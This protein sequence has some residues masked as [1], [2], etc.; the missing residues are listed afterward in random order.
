MCACR[1]TSN[2]EIWI[3]NISK[4]GDFNLIDDDEEYASLFITQSSN[5]ESCVSLEEDEGNVFKTVHNSDYSDIS[6]DEDAQIDKH[7]R[8]E[9]I[10]FVFSQCEV[11]GLGIMF[12]VNKLIIIYSVICM[13]K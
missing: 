13:T 4:M 8:Y 7:L 5:R 11:T 3:T 9:K 12:S 10:G 2:S 1:L 6:E